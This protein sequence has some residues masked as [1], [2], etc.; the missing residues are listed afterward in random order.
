MSV[1]PSI[2]AVARRLFGRH[3]LRRAERQ[4]GLR[5]ATAAGVRHGQ[6]DAE[7]GDQRLAVLHED[8]L[9]LEVAMN[10]VVPVRVVERARDR[11]RDADRLID[12][13]LL[14][15][16]ECAARSVSPSTYGMT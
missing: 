1:R 5:D 10:H 13:E 15:A 11:R 7:V 12:R 4:S 14:L 2:G 3:V 16:I 6:R 9:G 8:V